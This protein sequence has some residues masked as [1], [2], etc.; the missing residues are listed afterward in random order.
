MTHTEIA[1]LMTRHAR[2]EVTAQDVD[3]GTVLQGIPDESLRDDLL[4]MFAEYT[5]HGFHGGNSL[6]L[7]TIL[8]PPRSLDGIFAELPR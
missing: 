5:A 8:G 4:A 6:T 2:R 7:R 1:A 3:P